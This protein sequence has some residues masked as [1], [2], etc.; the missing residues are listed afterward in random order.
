MNPIYKVIKQDGE[1]FDPKEFLENIDCPEE[2]KIVIRR[3]ALGEK[4][5]QKKESDYV[6]Y[7]N[8]LGFDWEPNSDA[9]FLRYDYKANLIMRL[10]KEYSRKLVGEIG[11]PI[12]EVQGSNFFDLKHPVVQAYAN[13][14]GDRLFKFS[15]DKND[16][17]MSYDGSYPQFNLAKEY[18]ISEK[19]LPFAHFSISDCYR[20]EQSGECMLLLRGRRF[21]MPDL[22]PYFKDVDQAWEWYPEIEEKICEAANSVDREYWN[23]VKVSSEKYWEIY[24]EQIIAIAKRRDKPVLV[25]VRRDDVGRYWI[26]DVD[27]SIVDSF[28]QVREIGCIQI[29][30][31]NAERLDIKYKD[32]KNKFHHPVIIHAA[33]PGGIERFI[34]LAIDKFKDKFPLWLHPIQLRLIPVNA[35]YIE[36]CHKIVCEN[37]G[38]RIDIDDRD[39]NINRRIRSAHE[40]LVPN[41]LLIGEREIKNNQNVVDRVQE[42]RNKISKLPFI[43]RNWPAEVSKLPM[44]N[45]ARG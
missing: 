22:H 7:A 38:I 15:S 14:F 45:V 1:I 29:D 4:I 25:E 31:G 23:V 39:E 19:Q 40:E 34:Y 36:Y 33:V 42:I 16:L 26:V 27:Y 3:E 44:M 32:S 18:V 28:E 5:F 17:V 10:V 20:Y 2:F 21:N 13:L 6:K 11:F 8:K 37:P 43:Q 41:I 30:I 35:K 24:K 12:L 9:G